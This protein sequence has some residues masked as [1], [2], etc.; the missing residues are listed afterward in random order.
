M[1]KLISKKTE[2]MFIEKKKL[3]YNRLLV[4]LDLYLN[5]FICQISGLSTRQTEI[6]EESTDLAR[7]KDEV[8]AEKFQIQGREK[9]LQS[10]YRKASS[11]Y[12]V[13]SSSNA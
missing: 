13:L 5:K 2:L 8:L 3:C 10:S 1:A 11:R 12:E 9:E 7:K 4:H 6:E